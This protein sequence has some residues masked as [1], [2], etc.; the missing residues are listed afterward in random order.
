MRVV[1]TVKPSI[2]D[3]SDGQTF[4]SRTEIVLTLM[5]ILCTL[6]KGPFVERTNF[7]AH[8]VKNPLKTDKLT[9]IYSKSTRKVL[10]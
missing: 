6:L 1:H 5:N 4:L 3:T 10:F 8:L 7:R 9:Y 2:T